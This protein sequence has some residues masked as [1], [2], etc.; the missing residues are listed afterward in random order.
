MAP[1]I[2]TNV[3]VARHDEYVCLLAVVRR[4][5]FTVPSRGNNAANGYLVQYAL[6]PQ[7]DYAHFSIGAFTGCL[8]TIL[9]F[10]YELKNN[11]SVVISANSSDIHVTTYP[12]TVFVLHVNKVCMGCGGKQR[13]SRCSGCCVPC[14]TPS[15]ALLH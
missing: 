10:R 9:P 2:S 8:A 13:C 7:G 12:M 11:Y 3:E 4:P 14:A 15:G 6:L 1:I 5:Y